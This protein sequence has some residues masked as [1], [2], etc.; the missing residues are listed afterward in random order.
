MVQRGDELEV[1]EDDVTL[2]ATDVLTGRGFRHW[3]VR[4]REV[5][6]GE[7]SSRSCSTTRRAS[8]SSTR[9]AST[10]ASR[11]STRCCTWARATL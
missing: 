3:Q 7:R 5:E 2:P 9:T 8:S 10:T 1:T 6:H 4:L 11:R